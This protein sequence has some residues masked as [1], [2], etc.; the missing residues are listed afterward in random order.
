MRIPFIVV[1]ALLCQEYSRKYHVGVAE[2][3]T[4][5]ICRLRPPSFKAARGAAATKQ[6]QKG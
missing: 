3:Q 4:V 1:S 5:N 6:L 2:N